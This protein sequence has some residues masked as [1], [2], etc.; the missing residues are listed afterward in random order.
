MDQKHQW[1][2]LQQE[3][4]SMPYRESCKSS[5]S[6]IL[7]GWLH[8]LTLSWCGQCWRHRMCLYMWHPKPGTCLWTMGSKI[9]YLVEINWRLTSQKVPVR[10]NP[11][12]IINIIIIIIIIIIVTVVSSSPDVFVS[13]HFTNTP[14]VSPGAVLLSVQP[15]KCKCR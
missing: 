13:W 2:P 1:S 3:Q 5:T 8:A 15:P 9:N 12:P 11:N 14:S 4:N 7:H 6:L 10:V